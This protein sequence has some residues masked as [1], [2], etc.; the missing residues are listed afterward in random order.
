MNS[1]KQKIYDF[2][3]TKNL[4]RDE[5]ASLNM[6]DASISIVLAAVTMGIGAMILGKIFPQ[7]QGTD[8]ASIEAIAA[9]QTT[10]WD[11]LALLPIALVIFAAVE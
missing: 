4:L 1:L 6:G 5:Q 11:A 9:I 3:K 10:T 8:E 2:A 7:I